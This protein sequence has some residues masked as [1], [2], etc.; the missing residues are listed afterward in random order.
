MSLENI[1][2]SDKHYAKP[3]T[4]GQIFY[5]STSISRIVKFIETGSRLEVTRGWKKWGVN[6]CQIGTEFLFGVIKNFGN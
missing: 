2:L 6:Y 3:D 4:K 5:D 1:V